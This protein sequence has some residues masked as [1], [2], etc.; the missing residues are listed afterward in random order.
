MR[1]V[2][3]KCFSTEYIGNNTCHLFFGRPAVA[4]VQIPA[5]AIEGETGAYYTA[6]FPILSQVCTQTLSHKRGIQSTAATERSPA[7]WRETGG[8][9]VTSGSDDCRRP[10]VSPR[11]TAPD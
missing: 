11:R 6:Q 3:L 10:R 9:Y 5:E 7:E 8:H 2:F 4:E 1:S